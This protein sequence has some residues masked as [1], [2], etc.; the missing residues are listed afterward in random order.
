MEEASRIVLGGFTI[1]TEAKFVRYPERYM[2]KRGTAMWQAV[3]E[4][5]GGFG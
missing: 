4:L 1:R 5:V 2:D 3:S